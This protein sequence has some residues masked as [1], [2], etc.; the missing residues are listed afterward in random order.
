MR[1]EGRRRGAAEA[2][3][4]E[5]VEPLVRG[6]AGEEQ[7]ARAEERG[8]G[9][10][11]AGVDGAALGG[12]E[13]AVEGRVGGEHGALAEDVGGEHAAVARHALVD[14]RL[15][16]GRLVRRDEPQRLANQRQARAPRRHPRPL[17]QPPGGGAPEEE[18]PSERHGNHDGGG[19]RG[20][21][22]QRGRGHGGV[23]VRVV[24]KE[25]VRMSEIDEAPTTRGSAPKGRMFVGVFVG[26]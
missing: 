24:G 2:G 4:G 8:D 18:E 6:A 15:R 7:G 23:A 1:E 14:E 10:R 11:V 25:R 22:E 9:G 20:E 3:E 12:E 16:V 17:P 5:G 26:G 19:G 21:E 13:E